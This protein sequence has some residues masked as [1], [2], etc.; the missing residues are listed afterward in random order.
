[1]DEFEDRAVERIQRLTLG[2]GLT[3]SAA[4]AFAFGWQ[5]G[6]AFF[7]GALASWLNFRWLKRFVMTLGQVAAAAKSPPRKRVAVV[8]GLRYLIL[9]AGAYVIVKYSELSLAAALA[10]LFVAVAAVIA[11]ILFELIYAGT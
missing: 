9:A 1:V 11:E 7:L 3:G 6:A 2:L 8:F 4:G 5:W 10:G